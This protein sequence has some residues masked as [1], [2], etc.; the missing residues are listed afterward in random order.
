MLKIL[1][2]ETLIAEYDS[3]L[4]FPDGTDPDTK[5]LFNTVI[6]TVIVKPQFGSKDQHVANVFIEAGYVVEVIPEAEVLEGADF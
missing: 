4:T 5:K 1:D 3:E 6:D 2:N